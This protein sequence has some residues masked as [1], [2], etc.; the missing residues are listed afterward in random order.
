MYKPKPKLSILKKNEW[1][2][3]A[4]ELWIKF[5]LKN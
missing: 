3:V 1:E 2:I 4:T 5:I